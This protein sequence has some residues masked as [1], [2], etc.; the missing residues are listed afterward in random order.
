M[1]ASKSFQSIPIRRAGTRDAWRR[2]A[3]ST[4]IRHRAAHR[5]RCAPR[6]HDQLARRNG[7]HGGRSNA[8]LVAA[9]VFTVSLQ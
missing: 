5:H 3:D 4:P 2:Q 7:A 9:L 6:R 8:A 1:S